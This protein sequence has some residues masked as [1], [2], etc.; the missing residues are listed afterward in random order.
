M[1]KKFARYLIT[2]AILSVIKAIP[3][4]A[5]LILAIW[6]VA[7]VLLVSCSTKP[8]IAQDYYICELKTD[9]NLNGL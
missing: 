2:D 6:L 4:L 9:Q 5:M 3:A 8:I 7:G 1:V